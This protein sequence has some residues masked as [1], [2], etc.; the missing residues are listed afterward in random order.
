MPR[1]D[2]TGPAGQ[3]PMTGRAAGVCNGF[4]GAGC[5][6]RFGIGFGAGRGLGSGRGLRAAGPYGGYADEKAFLSGQAELLEK[7]LEQVR[8]R[9][10]QL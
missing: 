6:R 2:G 3:G 7:R 10:S 4:A 5:G 8:E 1:G 9:L